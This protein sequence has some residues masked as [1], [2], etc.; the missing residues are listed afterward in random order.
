[1]GRSGAVEL[2]VRLRRAKSLL[3]D[4]PP[5]LPGNMLPAK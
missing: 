2:R 3:A 1:M 4:S 5:D